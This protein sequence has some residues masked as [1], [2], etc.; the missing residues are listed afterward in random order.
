[1]ILE[2]IRAFGALGTRA[3]VGTLIKMIV[4]PDP[5]AD[6][7]EQIRGAVNTALELITGVKQGYDS[8]LSDAQRQAA[9]DNW[10]LWWKKNKDTWK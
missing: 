4:T 5:D 1:M 6:D 9:V 3:A 7:P 10:R 8:T 2:T